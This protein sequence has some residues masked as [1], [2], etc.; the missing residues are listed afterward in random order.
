MS[1]K[2][3]SGTPSSVASTSCATRGSAQR[4]EPDQ[5]GAR[6]PRQRREQLGLGSG[7]LRPSREHERNIQLLQAR[8]QEGQVAKR[9]G[10]GPMG[11]VNDQA[12]GTGRREVGAQPV[13]AVEDGE[14]DIQAERRRVVGSRGGAWQ[15]EDGRRRAG[16]R[17]QQLAPL[18]LGCVR[19]RRLEELADDA[20]RELALELGSPRAQHP[21]PAR[22]RRV[23]H[24][25]EHRRLP[26][27][28]RPFQHHEPA[29]PGARL[30]QGGIDVRELVDPFEKP[31]AERLARQMPSA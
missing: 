21:H 30:V 16:G 31:C 2:S 25:S 7:L 1:T 26:D 15:I 27:P 20:E 29:T 19:Q 28:G 24:R 3:G 22:G 6:I 13:E 8:E 4:G 18:E 10:V 17:V 14:R 5:I 12:D 11:V 9:W 23:P